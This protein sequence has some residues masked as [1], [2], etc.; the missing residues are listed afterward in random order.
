MPFQSTRW[1]PLRYDPQ[2]PFEGISSSSFAYLR[3][4]YEPKLDSF[5]FSYRSR[6][7]PVITF[8]DLCLRK[9][10]HS[11]PYMWASQPIRP[12]LLRFVEHQPSAFYG[13]AQRASRLGR[14]REAALLVCACSIRR[15]PVTVN[16]WLNVFFE[17]SAGSGLSRRQENSPTPEDLLPAR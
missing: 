5:D 2:E 16:T 12:G 15:K 7:L 10:N 11:Y 6:G 3:G 9:A 17:R 4:I 8:R 13:A 14:H 1:S